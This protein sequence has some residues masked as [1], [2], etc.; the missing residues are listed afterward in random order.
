MASYYKS[1]EVYKQ[2]R[3]QNNQSEIIPVRGLYVSGTH[4]EPLY[5]DHNITVTDFTSTA[6]SIADLIETDRDMELHGCN[7]LDFDMINNIDIVQYTRAT[8]T[9]SD[10][11]GCNILDFD[12]INNIDIY[13]YQKTETTLPDMHGN[14]VLDFDIE[15]S[16]DITQ[17]TSTDAKTMDSMISINIFTSD[18][19]RFS[20]Y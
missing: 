6:V 3:N 12:M 9:L 2:H 11:H 19:L 7:V 14:N 15:N 8:A 20:D 16:F 13:S 5:Q 4:L 10:L 1:K 18:N 17:L